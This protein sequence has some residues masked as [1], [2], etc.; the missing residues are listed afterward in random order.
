MEEGSFD[1]ESQLKME[2]YRSK[3]LLKDNF[4]MSFTQI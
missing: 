3:D 2:L 1:D 4:L